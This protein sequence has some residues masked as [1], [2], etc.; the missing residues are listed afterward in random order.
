MNDDLGYSADELAEYNRLATQDQEVND[1]KQSATADQKEATA[2]A[3]QQTNNDVTATDSKPEPKQEEQQQGFDAEN[4]SG[5]MYGSGMTPNLGEDVSQFANQAAQRIGAAGF[6]LVD[7]AVGAYNW[8]VPG[9]ENDIQRSGILAPFD[10]KPAQVARDLSAAIL[11]ELMAYGGAVKLLGKAKG[12]LGGVQ[13]AASGANLGKL[14]KTLQFLQQSAGVK[15]LA[16]AGAG[17]TAAVGAAEVSFDPYNEIKEG[18]VSDAGMNASGML[19]H[20]AGWKFLPDGI[21]VAADD[22]P[23]EKRAKNKLEAAMFGGLE[24]VLGAGFRMLF[25][26]GGVYKATEYIPD[27]ENA[28]KQTEKLN[29]N[30][31]SFTGNQAVD[32]VISESDRINKDL[33]DYG[34]YMLSKMQQLDQPVKG[35]H[36]NFD[37][38]EVGLRTRDPDG[39]IGAMNDTYRIA[40]NV[41][42]WNGRVGSMFTSA[43]GKFGLELDN[44]KKGWLVDKVVDEIITNNGITTKLPSGKTITTT[45]RSQAVTDMYLAMTD[46]A[47]DASSIIELAEV[48]AKK[49]PKY[50]KGIALEAAGSAMRKYADTYLNLPK[51]QANALLQSS[52]AGQVADMADS[53][54]KAMGK[55]DVTQLQ[56]E[57]M[58]RLKALMILKEIDNMDTAAALGDKNLLQRW[59]MR[60]DEAALK[61]MEIRARRKGLTREER[62]EAQYRKVQDY[63]DVIEELR[64]ERPEWMKPLMMMFEATNGRVSTMYQMNN[65]IRQSLGSLRKAIYD[66]QP[67]FPQLIMKE[68]QGALYNSTLSAVETGFNMM[69]GTYQGIVD[70]AIAP[71]IG[72]LTSGDFKMVREHSSALAAQAMHTRS[73]LLAGVERF[74]ELSK[75]P[76]KWQAAM[77]PDYALKQSEL[78]ESLEAAA[79]AALVEGNDGIYMALQQ[80]QQIH[81]MNTDPLMRLIPNLGGGFDASA[82]SGIAWYHAHRRAF[83]QLQRSGRDMASLGDFGKKRLKVLERRIYQDMFDENGLLREPLALNEAQN[84]TLTKDNFLGDALDGIVKQIPAVKQAIMFPRMMGATAEMQ[85]NYTAIPLMRSMG[86]FY[87]PLNQMSMSEM[88]KILDDKGIKVSDY[89]VLDTFRMMRT[90]ARGR[91]TLGSAVL[92]VGITGALNGRLRG[93]GHYDSKKQKARGK[94]WQRSTY[95]GLDGKWHSHAWMGP[96]S[97]LLNVIADVQDN[98]DLL[99]EQPM[100]QINAKL[101]FVIGGLFDNVDMM[102]G[103]QPFLDAIAGKSGALDRFGAQYINRTM[104]MSGFR[105]DWSDFLDPQLDEIQRDLG[106]YLRASNGWLDPLFPE[107]AL[108]DHVNIMGQTIPGDIDIMTRMKNAFTPFKT[109]SQMTPEEVF[110]TRAEYPMDKAFSSVDGMS[111]EPLQQQEL[112]QMVFKDP[113]WQRGLRAI[114]KKYRYYDFEGKL[115]AAREAGDTSVDTP[116]SKFFGLHTEIDQLAAKVRDRVAP[117]LSDWNYLKAQQAYSNINQQRAAQGKPAAVRADEFI[118]EMNP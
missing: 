115:Q 19:K 1:A 108:A 93:N 94:D 14:E 48:M 42:S 26:R 36:S 95:M 105:S 47:A 5:F 6:G 4:Y 70:H 110:L 60:G 27:V 30:A 90:K 49:M 58:D 61:N 52:M 2:P 11:P 44:V 17:I 59:L 73:S 97:K 41:D 56:D 57:M 87:K 62:I 8:L 65:V 100:E 31:K 75:D 91:A 68:M 80:R 39:V 20:K 85:Y 40:N 37:A 104:P 83:L 3:P 18:E 46:P 66:G 28:V 78:L 99:G 103:L 69:L 106:G 77:K 29:A 84:I 34:A 63:I 32:K 79:D 7:A 112:S 50:G 23:E 9:T 76:D 16:K 72:A 81:A 98:F 116:I 96:F 89:E 117:Q 13:M 53:A 10:D 45:Q 74:K 54:S 107:T 114:V 64:T 38:I 25:N 88:R 71:Y 33:D 12:A 102:A 118:K 86:G 55:A 51:M 24:P 67:E 22:T 111:L 113:E 15:V 43:A 21:A 101:A 82:Q 35:V 109:H 92:G